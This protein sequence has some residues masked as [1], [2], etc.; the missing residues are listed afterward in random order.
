M[1]QCCNHRNHLCDNEFENIYREVIINFP[2][3]AYYQLKQSLSKMLIED[4]NNNFYS[5]EA[6]NI[7]KK[8][9]LPSNK[10]S[11]IHKEMIPSW[12]M[13]WQLA[14][15]ENLQANLLTWAFGYLK[16]ETQR[17]EILLEIIGTT[18]SYF[19]TSSFLD[20]L[21]H[22]LNINLISTTDQ[23][24]K[25]I[26]QLATIK[27]KL[28][29]KPITNEAVFEME[30]I[31]LKFSNKNTFKKF[32]QTMEIEVTRIYMKC[33]DYNSNNKLDGTFSKKMFYEFNRDFTFI[34]NPV[35]LRSQYYNF[36]N[37]TVSVRS[38][39]SSHFNN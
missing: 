25:C 18:E 24:Y 6:Y 39:S 38:R 23:I 4:N 19:D 35:L 10:Y 32:F 21:W 26:L 7:F 3:I 16:D 37:E 20:F 8:S 31:L 13:I 12:L 2:G 34:W 9:L 15:P 1:G 14:Y 17:Y 5:E 11:Q 30:Q 28:D 33:S 27:E 36:I 22:Y 29:N